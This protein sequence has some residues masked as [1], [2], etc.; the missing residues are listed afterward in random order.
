MGIIAWIVFGFVIGLI[1]RAV[2]PGKQSL[3]FVMTTLLGIA[4]SLIGGL[5]ASA[6][7]GTSGTTFQTAGFI[8]SLVGAIVLLVIA[9]MVTTPRRR[10]V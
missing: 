10:T 7:A 8:G 9:G 2:V 4:G 3:G 6:F 1:A 5:V